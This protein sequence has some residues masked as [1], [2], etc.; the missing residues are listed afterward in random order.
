MNM[1][2]EAPWL[3]GAFAL[4]FFV[5]GWVLWRGS[6]V[7]YI[8]HGWHWELLPLMVGVAL[9]LTWF[10]GLRIIS[11]ALVVGSTFPA[12]IFVRIVL[13]G[14]EDSTNHNLMPFEL[15]AAFIFGML[16]AFPSAG[17]GWLLRRITYR[18][19]TEVR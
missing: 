14:M 5:E 7:E 15:A 10:I 13:D 16:V 4:C 3:A 19:R 6:Y 12:V 8:E 17:I 9:V 11:S 1:R 2:R 18:R